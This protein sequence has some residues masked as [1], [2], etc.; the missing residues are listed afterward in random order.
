MPRKRHPKSIPKRNQRLAN[1]RLEENDDRDTD[2]QQSVAERELKRR[3]ILFDGKPVEKNEGD[4]AEGH[5]CGARAAQEFQDRIHKQKDE[6]DVCEIAQLDH[7][8]QILG[9]WQ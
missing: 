4:D 8:S 3:E 7:P 2:V 6:E 1:F 9:V 5:R